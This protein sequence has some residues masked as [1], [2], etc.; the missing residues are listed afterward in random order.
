[1][2]TLQNQIPSHYT[3][4]FNAFYDEDGSGKIA[5][6]QYDMA[7][8]LYYL[9]LNPHTYKLNIRDSKSIDLSKTV[10][11]LHFQGTPYAKALLTYSF[12]PYRLHNYG[13]VQGDSA[14]GQFFLTVDLCPSKKPLD[15]ELFNRTIELQQSRDEAVPVAVAI[16]GLWMRRHPQ[17]LEWLRS[18]MEESK[19]NIT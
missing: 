11:P 5:I 2:D 12:P 18:Q 10:P 3:F 4:V 1:M 14:S 13:I 6:R 17:D 15:R 9:V 8:G 7:D 16:S 19:L